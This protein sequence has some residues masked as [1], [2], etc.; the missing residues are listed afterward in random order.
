MLVTIAGFVCIVLGTMVAGLTAYLLKEMFSPE[1]EIE[2]HD[3]PTIVLLSIVSV[4][5]FIGGL[6]IYGVRF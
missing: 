3:L 4:S 5:L 2:P 1:M 6:S